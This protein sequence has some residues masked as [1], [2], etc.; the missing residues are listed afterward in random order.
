GTVDP[1]LVTNPQLQS[2]LNTATIGSI[3]P[4]LYEAYPDAP[5]MLDLTMTE[6]PS[7]SVMPSAVFANVTGTV[8]VSVQDGTQGYVPALDLGFSVGMAGKPVSYNKPWYALTRSYFYFDYSPY[9]VSAW[10]MDSQYGDVHLDTPSAT[11]LETYLSALAVV[12]WLN[13]WTEYHAPS[14]DFAGGYYDFD[15]YYTVLKEPETIVW[16]VPMQ[17]LDEE[18]E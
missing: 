11:V 16:C 8:H 5:I 10:E 12:P 13:D 14:F 7:I 17:Y 4:G 1:A 2:L 18:A 3:C 9:N 15:D 6:T